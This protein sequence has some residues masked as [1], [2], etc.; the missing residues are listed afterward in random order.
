MRTYQQRNLCPACGYFHDS[1]STVA[2]DRGKPKPGDL[3]VC[4]NCGALAAFT[5]DLRLKLTTMPKD[6]TP[7]QRLLIEKAQGYIR[8]RGPL[9]KRKTVQ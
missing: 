9:P 4:L 5:D 3:S 1:A 8:Q 2:R 6:A 7:T